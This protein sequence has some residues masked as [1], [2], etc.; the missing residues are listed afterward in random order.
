M[1]IRIY[2]SM[3]VHV[4]LAV[5]MHEVSFAP[6]Q[7]VVGNL[8]SGPVAVAMKDTPC[9]GS[10]LATCTTCK[11]HSAKLLLLFRGGR[12]CLPTFLA[13]SFAFFYPRFL[14]RKVNLILVPMKIPGLGKCFR[15]V[16]H[17]TYF[18]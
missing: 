9:F 17:F 8:Y 18:V 7:S 12:L 15:R 16:L 4:C 14:R 11:F 2:R 1:D 5:Y 13:G 10:L 3:F 6:Y